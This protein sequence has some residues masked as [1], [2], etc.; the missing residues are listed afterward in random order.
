MTEVVEFE[1]RKWA[2]ECR[3]RTQEL[4]MKEDE[5]QETIRAQNKSSWTI[6]IV[7]AIFAA[8]LAGIGNAMF[9][10]INGHNQ[11]VLEMEKFT[12]TQTIEEAKAESDRILEVVEMVDQDKAAEN[13]YFLL[14][15]HLINNEDR[16]KALND[17]LDTRKGEKDL[18]FPKIILMLT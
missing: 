6:P 9:A 5:L 2:E 7:V 14:K 12:Q 4:S 3:L 16:R 11:L 8:T 18:V 17:Y 15:A 1:Q 13:I 10:W